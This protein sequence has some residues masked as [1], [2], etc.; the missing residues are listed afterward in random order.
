LAEDAP[1][2][3]VWALDQMRQKHPTKEGWRIDAFPCCEAI[4]DEKVREAA[5]ILN[6]NLNTPAEQKEQTNP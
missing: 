1:T 5:A 4:P 2:L 6:A 3:I